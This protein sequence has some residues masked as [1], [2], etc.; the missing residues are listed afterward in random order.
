MSKLIDEQGGR[1]KEEAIRHIF[2]ARDSEA[3]LNI[4]IVP[5]LPMDH[6][7]WHY[8]SNGRF[9][10]RSCYHLGMD[11]LKRSRGWGRVH[12]FPVIPRHGEGFGS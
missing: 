3:I 4:F 8:T 5:S 6:M 9:M 11:F 1:W 2:N 7:V 12:Q 10:V